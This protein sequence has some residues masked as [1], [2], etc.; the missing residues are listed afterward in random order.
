M[1]ISTLSDFHPAVATW[2]ERRFPM[3]ATEAQLLGWQSIASGD[4]TLIA[5]PTGSGKTLAAF[6]VAIDRC[7]RGAMATPDRSHSTSVVY[8]SPLR[9]LTVDIAKNL[10]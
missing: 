5:A 6:L 3:G 10:T 7:L 4:D 1:S 9:A 8:V 2:F